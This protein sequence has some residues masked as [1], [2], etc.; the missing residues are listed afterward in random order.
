MRQGNTLAHSCRRCSVPEEP[1][2]FAK[3]GRQNGGVKIK[4]R[5]DEMAKGTFGERL[6][7]ERELREVTIKEIASAT[8][9]AAKFLQALENEEWEKLPGGVFGRGFVRSVARY[10]GL[11]EENLLSDYDQARGEAFTPATQKPEERIPSPPRWIPAIAVVLLV[12]AVVGLGV[13]CWYEAANR[14][15]Q[16]RNHGGHTGLLRHP[17]SGA[18]AH[19]LY[20]RW[21]F[22]D[23]FSRRLSHRH[24]RNCCCRPRAGEGSFDR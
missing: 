1:R 5:F 18:G 22:A 15:S 24:S 23:G 11:S 4:E 8:R 6:K 10:L 17:R 13:T 9:I 14:V 19:R 16:P 7:R 21:S 2:Y 20:R 3:I 12:A